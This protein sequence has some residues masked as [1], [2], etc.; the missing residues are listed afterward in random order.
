M[1]TEP[2]TAAARPP[3]SRFWRIAN[4]VVLGAL[5]IVGLLI[6]IGTIVT[7]NDLPA[8]DS[9]A[10]RDTLSDVNKKNQ[11]NATHYNGFETLSSSPDEIRCRAD[12]ALRGGGRILIEY[13]VFRQGKEKRYEVTRYDRVTG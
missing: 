10:M 11:A 4:M 13:R 8:C 7:R 3:A 6:A 12:L 1:S 2:S 9:R 5:I